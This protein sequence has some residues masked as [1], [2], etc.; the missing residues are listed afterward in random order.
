[1]ITFKQI[2]AVYWV[3]RLGSFEAA[4]DFLNTTQS[5]VSK[6]V[7]DLESR[8]GQSLFD[9]S[10]RS[11]Q[12]TPLGEQIVSL[13]LP[14]LDQR[15]AILQRL[16]RPATLRRKLRLGVTELTALTWLPDLVRGIRATYPHVEIIPEVN[17]SVT[18]HERLQSN[19]IDVIIV[20]DIFDDNRYATHPLGKVENVWMCAPS[21]AGEQRQ[22]TLEELTGRMLIV[23]GVLS[24]MAKAYGQWFKAQGA[25]LSRSIVCSNLLA[26][27]GLA[28]SGLATAYLPKH[29]LGVLQERK[30]LVALEVTPPLPKVQYVAIHRSPAADIFMDG[31]FHIAEQSCNFTK[32]IIQDTIDALEPSADG[33][34]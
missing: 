9:R 26:Q 13:A 32:F 27:I 11:S 29:C 17:L 2:E 14:L 19:S 7:Q 21:L 31:I 24:G 20:P 4:A 30:L 5:A 3:A 8:Y 6:R 1:M 34:S 28:V 10:R 23:Q 15:D 22:F 33:A 25:D 18:L 12:L 16:E